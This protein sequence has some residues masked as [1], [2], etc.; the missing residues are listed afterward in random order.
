LVIVSHPLLNVLLEAACGI[1]E[2]LAISVSPNDLMASS[3]SAVWGA[4]SAQTFG[5]RCAL[6]LPMLCL[7]LARRSW[8]GWMLNIDMRFGFENWLRFSPSVEHSAGSY[9]QLYKNLI[10]IYRNLAC[11]QLHNLMPSFPKYS[12]GS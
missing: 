8:F 12:V 4:G 2:A 9:K 11:Y 7:W 10:I 6:Q 1:T 3:P 5:G